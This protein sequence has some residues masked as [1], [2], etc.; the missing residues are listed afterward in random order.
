MQFCGG[1]VVNH[2]QIFKRKNTKNRYVHTCISLS[3][4]NNVSKRITG[5]TALASAH[6]CSAIAQHALIT[7]QAPIWSMPE[8]SLQTITYKCM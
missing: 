3:G 8:S 4:K 7:I 2:N 1:Q 6:R 5:H